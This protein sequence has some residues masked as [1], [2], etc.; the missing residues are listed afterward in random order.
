MRIENANV[1]T[2]RGRSERASTLEVHGDLIT[3]VDGAAA[4]DV[5]W[6]LEGRTVVPGFVDAHTHFHYWATTL[7]HLD[8]EPPLSLA[9]ALALVQ[10]RAAKVPS[11]HW[12][13][14]RGVNK[15]RWTPPDFPTRYDLDSVAPDHPVA[16]F[17]K[18]EHSLWV[19]SAAL[20]AA[21]VDRNTPDP[22]GGRIGR[23]ESGEPTGLLFETAYELIWSRIDEPDPADTIAALSQAAALV[24]PLG[25]T[26]VH[27]VGMW[28]AWEAYRLWDDRALDVVKYF[29]V[30]KAEEVVRLGLRS[31]DGNPEL[32][33]GGLKLFSDGA[34]GSQTAYMWEP[35]EGPESGTGVARL[36]SHELREYLDFAVAHELACA[37]HAIGDRANSMVIDS[38]LAYRARPLRH[39]VEHAQLL[40]EADVGRL[41]DSGWIASVQPSHLVSDRDM[42]LRYWGEK[43]CRHAYAFESMRR[44]GV[45]L[46]FG[47]DVPIE[48][49]NPIFGIYAACCRKSPDDSRGAWVSEECVDRYDALHA[50]TAGAAY[51]AGIESEVGT[52]APGQRANLVVL[53]RD[54]LSVPDTEILSV[55]VLATIVGGRPVYVNSAAAP[56]LAETIGSTAV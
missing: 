53:D 40:R 16:L 35:F 18:D 49:V 47:T 26:S 44:A 51:A 48:P 54:I 24:S 43:R 20:R 31:G 3:A 12:V 39:R 56:D 4:A 28:G 32:R 8:M 29:P 11:G 37:V 2:M 52:I 45:P 5:V 41:A 15:N 30:D 14:G 36:T 7:D 25:V 50:T 9:E 19:N 55:Q 17:S 46:A 38:A 42:A 1:I 21:G 6:D 23:D 13:L 34:L 22:P 10:A 27:D 33:I